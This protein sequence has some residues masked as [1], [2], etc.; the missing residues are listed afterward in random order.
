MIALTKRGQRDL[1]MAPLHKKQTQ[2]TQTIVLIHPWFQ[3]LCENA[4]TTGFSR[5]YFAF[6]LEVLR[7]SLF[8]YH[9]L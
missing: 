9:R 7:S 4:D 2:E 3:R 1:L 8:G 6:T 5:W